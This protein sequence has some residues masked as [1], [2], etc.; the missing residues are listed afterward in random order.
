VSLRLGIVVLAAG[1]ESRMTRADHPNGTC[2]IA[3]VSSM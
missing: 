1:F 3:E 2:R